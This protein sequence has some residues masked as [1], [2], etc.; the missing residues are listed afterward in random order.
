M[1]VLPEPENP[2][3]AVFIDV[4]YVW[5]GAEKAREA[6]ILGGSGA[7]CKAGCLGARYRR[8][9]SGPGRRGARA[10]AFVSGAD[11]P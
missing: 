4:P 11:L 2:K 3:I 7:G 6:R 9:A 1:S 8:L 5:N 10:W